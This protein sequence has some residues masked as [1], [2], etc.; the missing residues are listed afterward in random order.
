MHG[1]IMNSCLCQSVTC[2]WLL[3]CPDSVFFGM[4]TSCCLLS[5]SHML[6]FLS[7]LTEAEWYVSEP[8]KPRSCHPSSTPHVSS[9][10]RWVCWKGPSTEIPGVPGCG[11]CFWFCRLYPATCKPSHFICVRSSSGLSASVCLVYGRFS[12]STNTTLACK[13]SLHSCSTHLQGG[14]KQFQT[15]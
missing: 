14:M 15:C 13:P 8:R 4:H 3:E 12:P 7:I 1:C 5:Q 2:D 10:A 11:L 6:T 9:D